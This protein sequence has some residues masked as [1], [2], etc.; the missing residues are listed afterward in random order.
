MAFFYD[1]PSHTF[2]EYLL[3]PGYTSA[4]CI[5]EKVSLRTPVTRF[6]KRAGE[7]SDLYMNIPMVSAVMQSVSDDKMAIA[8]A[9]EGG[10]SFIFG[11]QTIENQ[12]AMVSRVK[13]YKAGFVTS[14]SNIRPDQTLEEVVALI[15]QTG[16]STIAVTQDGSAHGKLEGIITGRD[17]RI[18]HVPA[19][20]KVSDYMTPFKD[21]VT[22]DDG[23]SLSDANDL[24]WAHKVNQLPVIDKNGNLVSLVFRKDFDS[25][26]S[27]PNELLDKAHRYIVGAGI[28]TRDYMERVPALLKAGVDILCL[29]SSEG[30]SEWQA[31][32]LKD[33]HEKFGQNIKVGA[34]NV[35]DKEG[36]LFLAEKIWS[37]SEHQDS[38]DISWGLSLLT[39]LNGGRLKYPLYFQIR[40]FL[41]QDI[42]MF[43]R[44]GREDFVEKLIGH[45]PVFAQIN[46]E[47]FKF[48][49]RVITI[50]FNFNF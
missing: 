46:P 20:S 41:E 50:F 4:D 24:I 23:I 10:I 37:T 47:S 38:F 14:D 27:H 1:E 36:F 40:S 26:E 17:F 28:N 31:R 39:F 18:D 35:V 8:L 45:A 48:F 29:D 49:G 13:A 21:L 32:A 22:G 16:H 34:G 12:A 9:K 33:I 7:K 19:S 43:Y 5:P 2:G 11:S 44:M 6:N 3:I 30:Y 15:E 25:H 42:D